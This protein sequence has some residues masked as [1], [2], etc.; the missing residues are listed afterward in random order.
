MIKFI[1]NIEILSSNFKIIWNKKSDGGSFSWSDG[2]IEIGIKSY[3]T[4]PL[5][6]L[7]IL[8]HEIMEVILVGLG[9]RFSNGRTMD[10]YL[11]NF[12]HQT[13]ET[14]IK[15]YTQ[16]INKFLTNFTN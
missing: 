15:I 7:N 11:F 9:A 12:D 3:K 14:A 1:K 13:F 16:T 6:T 5:Y 8:N 4:D 2:I 10:N